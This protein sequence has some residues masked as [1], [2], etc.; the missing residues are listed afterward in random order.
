MI[1]ERKQSRKGA[2]EKE[3]KHLINPEEIRGL[4]L[5]ESQSLPCP[6]S[7]TLKLLHFLI[8]FHTGS[9]EPDLSAVAALPAPFLPRLHP[10]GA[11][12]AATTVPGPGSTASSLAS[13]VH[14]GQRGCPWNLVSFPFRK[15]EIKAKYSI[16]I[17]KK[18]NLKMPEICGLLFPMSTATAIYKSL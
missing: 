18:I 1:R 2:L 14:P 10:H 3:Q 4:C 9:W 5:G 13:Y 16:L 15:A 17:K 6:D 11:S 12:P 7:S 8:E